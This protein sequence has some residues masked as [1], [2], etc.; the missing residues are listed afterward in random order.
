[1]YASLCDSSGGLVASG[2]DCRI[3]D[4]Q[5]AYTNATA[6]RRLDLTSARRFVE[7]F[8]A[9]TRRFLAD[10]YVWEVSFVASAPL[11]AVAAEQGTGDDVA[12]GRSAFSSAVTSILS[13]AS[14]QSAAAT[15]LGIA[16]L[17]V[18]SAAISAV[19]STRNPSPVPSPAPSPGPSHPTPRPSGEVFTHT[20]SR[21][22][23]PHPTAYM[24]TRVG[25]SDGLAGISAVFWIVLG[26]GVGLALAIFFIRAYILNKPSVDSEDED[27]EAGEGDAAAARAEGRAERREVLRAAWLQEVAAS[28][29]SLAQSIPVIPFSE[30]KLGAKA[31]QA[32]TDHKDEEEEVMS[33]LAKLL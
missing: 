9:G 27:S 18:D 2:D 4:F 23:T 33:S 20:P 22:P 31:K 32:Y 25:I 30:S 19:L 26:S 12:T 29:V 6:R 3:L 16:S 8:G 24:P 1:M 21:E 5:V 7:D 17:T 28:R 11:S 15:T 14:F 10:S 13:D